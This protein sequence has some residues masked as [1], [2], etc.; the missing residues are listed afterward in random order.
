MFLHVPRNHDPA[1]SFTPGTEIT[2]NYS[3]TACKC[4]GN[5]VVWMWVPGE[6]GYIRKIKRLP[7]PTLF[8]LG[9]AWEVGGF[10]DDIRLALVAAAVDV[11]ARGHRPPG[12]PGRLQLLLERFHPFPGTVRISRRKNALSWGGCCSWVS[13]TE[14]R[15]VRAH[16]PKEK[17]SMSTQDSSAH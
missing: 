8:V 7:Y 10:G 6:E 14:P 4:H 1:G 15:S 16:L 12:A 9:L 11:A 3:S 17:R 2:R 13:P 5:L